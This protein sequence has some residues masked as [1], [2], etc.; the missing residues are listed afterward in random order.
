[1]L[2]NP[3][4]LKGGQTRGQKPTNRA[5]KQFIRK[6]KNMFRKHKIAKKNGNTWYCLGELVKASVRL[7]DEDP[8]LTED[9]RPPTTSPTNAQ[10]QHDTLEHHM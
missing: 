6:K 3:F 9:L 7:V 1:M 2:N 4:T 5:Q 10:P 8:E